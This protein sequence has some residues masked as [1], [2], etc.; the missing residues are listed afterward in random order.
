MLIAVGELCGKLHQ[1]SEARKQQQQQQQ[2]P[3]RSVDDD[4][5][6]GNYFEIY[7]RINSTKL[8]KKQQQPLHVKT[9]K[10]PHRAKGGGSHL[11]YA[12]TVCCTPFALEID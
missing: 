12:C 6:G 7:F 4:D 11:S 8:K 1:L 9:A 10:T 2:Q 3:P 5:D